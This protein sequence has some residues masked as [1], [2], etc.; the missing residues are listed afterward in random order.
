[1]AEDILASS[2]LGGI[3]RSDGKPCANAAYQNV[4]SKNDPVYAPKVPTWITFSIQ[5]QPWRNGLCLY[6]V[7]R[8]GYHVCYKIVDFEFATLDEIKDS[9]RSYVSQNFKVLVN[10]FNG[11]KPNVADWSW[12][13][14]DLFENQKAVQPP[15]MVWK[16]PGQ[17]SYC[18]HFD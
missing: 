11:N 16:C 3:L 8:L 17:D 2:M 4:C 13:F 9:I 7:Y 18:Y 10:L 15:K 5:Q 12:H 1:M 14:Q 6:S